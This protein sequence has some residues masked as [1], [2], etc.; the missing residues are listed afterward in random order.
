MGHDER[1]E[2]CDLPVHPAGTHPGVV[3]KETVPT[4]LVVDRCIATIGIYSTLLRT[5]S[6][7]R[8]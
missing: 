3:V 8:V 1:Q 4:V 7:F 6:P 5:L 2:R